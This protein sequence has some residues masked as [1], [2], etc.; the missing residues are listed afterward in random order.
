V[1]VQLD[2]GGTSR[3]MPDRSERRPASRPT[4]MF[5]WQASSYHGWGV[6]GLNLM[7]NWA[8]RR[9]F[10]ICCSFPIESAT[11]E[12]NPL[13]RWVIDQ[14]LVE[15]RQAWA[16]LQGLH[17]KLR[18]SCVVLH[19]LGNNLSGSMSPHELQLLGTPSIGV[20]F[21]EWSHFDKTLRKRASLYPL[22]VAGSTWNRDVLAGLGIDE[23][24]V[25]QQGVDTT[26]FHPAPRMGWFAN[27]FAVFS[28]GKLERRKG[29]DL[30]IQ[31]FRAFARRHRDALL[32]TAWSS[33]WPHLARSLNV[34]ASV[35]PVPF[36]DDEQVDALAWTQANG[37]SDQH[38]LHLGRVPNAQ[39]PRVLREMDVA[40]FPNRAEGGTNL[41]AME[42]MACGIPTILSANTGHRDLIRD[43]N[44]F[45]LER[46]GRVPE[47]GCQDW[48]ESDIEEIVESLET[49][50]RERPEARARGRRGAE[51]MAEL[52]W[53]RQSEKFADLIRPYLN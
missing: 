27:R 49:V 10:S 2:I 6:Y 24:E 19:G 50:Y 28:G 25:V 42:C 1:A 33:P 12:I 36:G 4:V 5:H 32:V 21:F 51:I 31:A 30:V 35:Q 8:A 14:I 13:E 9:D 45:P 7:L 20:V 34:N 26:H 47:P 37:I 41:V 38:V 53:A 52:T 39:M 40:L 17:G 11:L 18:L 48:G 16:R 29:Q 3:V 23:V 43:G 44:C 46:Q 22:I 15:S